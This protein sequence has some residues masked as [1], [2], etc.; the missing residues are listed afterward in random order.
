M[1]KL[2]VTGVLNNLFLVQ[3]PLSAGM[4]GTRIGK[5]GSPP[6]IE[7]IIS[8]DVWHQVANTWFTRVQRHVPRAT[9]DREESGILDTI[10]SQLMRV[11]SDTGDY[12]SEWFELHHAVST[13]T[14]SSLSQHLPYYKIWIIFNIYMTKIRQQQN[15]RHSEQIFY[16]LIKWDWRQFIIIACWNLLTLLICLGI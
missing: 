14:C 3:N 5:L 8:E 15:S 2:S 9:W 7:L 16:Q 1:R 4:G 12:T 6:T 10:T 11:R 13:S